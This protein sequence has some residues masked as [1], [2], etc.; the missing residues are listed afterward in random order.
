MGTPRPSTILIADSEP[1]FRET[2]A[3]YLRLRGYEV[4][5]AADGNDALRVLGDTPVDLVV[6]DLAVPKLSGKALVYAIR[7]D[8]RL[9][10]VPVIV[11]TACDRPDL[12]AS[13]RPEVQAW[14]V[15]PGVS[16]AQFLEHVKRHLPEPRG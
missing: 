2:V 11:A 5:T 7:A 13:V 9:R 10:A 4:R 14:L 6:L 8:P 1:N 12:E 3:V 15:K 16:L